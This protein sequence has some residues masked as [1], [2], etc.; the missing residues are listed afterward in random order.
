MAPKGAGVRDRL[1]LVGRAC[2]GVTG[3]VVDEVPSARRLPVRRRLGIDQAPVPAMIPHS[4][5][6]TSAVD[7]PPG[8]RRSVRRRVSNQF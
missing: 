6:E 1:G 4:V 5:P 2:A 3:P 8:I 7:E